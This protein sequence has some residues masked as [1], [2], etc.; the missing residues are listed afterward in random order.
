MMI[1]IRFFILIV[2][3]FSFNNCGK[4]TVRIEGIDGK[5]GIDGQS[6]PKGLDGK[7]GVLLSIVSIPNRGEC[8]FLGHTVNQVPVWAEN[9]T[10]HADYYNNDQCDHG[11]SPFTEYC[12]NTVEED[13][14]CLIDNWELKT[15]GVEGE[16]KVYILRFSL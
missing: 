8:V 3:V 16:M 11:P 2:L 14:H 1:L 6:G 15:H 4:E 10:Q 13:K 9:E 12:D 5:P 7:D